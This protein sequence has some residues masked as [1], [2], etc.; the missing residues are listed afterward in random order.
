MLLV[1]FSDAVFTFG[2]MNGLGPGLA[3]LIAAFTA[4]QKPFLQVM[5]ACER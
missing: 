1:H 5:S 4:L 2:G 3:A